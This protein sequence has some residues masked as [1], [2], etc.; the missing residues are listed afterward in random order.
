MS[1]RLPTH[2]FD[3]CQKAGLARKKSKSPLCAFLLAPALFFVATASEAAPAASLRGQATPGEQ[4]IRWSTPQRPTHQLTT[5]HALYKTEM[6]DVHHSWARLLERL[7][8]HRPRLFSSRC[9]DLGRHLR[10]VD[11]N[12]LLPAPEVLLDH[13]LKRMLFHLDHATRHCSADQLFNVVYRLEEA[14]SALAEIRFLLEIRGL[15]P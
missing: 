7:N 12:E 6:V 9:D 4:T 2:L 15:H 3:T 10:M 14:R 1:D 13:Y 11:A 5:W 8:S